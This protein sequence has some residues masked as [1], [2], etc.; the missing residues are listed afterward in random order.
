MLRKPLVY[1]YQIF[2]LLILLRPFKFS[3]LTELKLKKKVNL[4]NFKRE[5]SKAYIFIQI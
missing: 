3:N 1:F 2:K 4:K 5:M